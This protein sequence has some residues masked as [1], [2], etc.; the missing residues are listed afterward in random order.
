ME[1]IPFFRALM[2]PFYAASLGALTPEEA[3]ADVERLKALLDSVYNGIH[4]PD[5]GL[6]VDVAT[7]AG[8][9]A[10][11]A[12]RRWP[13][14]SVFGYDLAVEA[15]ERAAAAAAQAGLAN[16]TF[17]EA[18]AEALPLDDDAAD[19][20]TIVSSFNLFPD[21]AAALAEARRVLRVGGTL[22][23]GESVRGTA[24]QTAV[25]E[26]PV[27]LTRQLSSGPGPLTEPDLRS[28]LAAAGFVVVS[29]TDVTA[30]RRALDA[31]KAWRYPALV[32]GFRYVVVRAS[33]V[34]RPL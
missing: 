16:V 31:S 11:D 19:L 26:A 8:L 3:L 15:C 10:L 14:A 9:A 18:D 32:E 24:D 7:G 23:I 1:D 29:V 25:L 34:R 6:A 30:T 5:G 4:V 21:K 27:Q 12:A 13:R 33:V 28:A 20:V 22:V 17:A 2:R